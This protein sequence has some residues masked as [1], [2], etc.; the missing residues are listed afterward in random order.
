M[1]D[2]QPWYQRLAA[3]PNT[4]P[5]QPSWRDDAACRGMDVDLFFPDVGVTYDSLLENV[6][7]G[8][9]QVRRECGEFGDTQ[10]WGIWGGKIIGYTKSRYKAPPEWVDCQG[11]GKSIPNQRGGRLRK[12]CG[13]NCRQQAER[14]AS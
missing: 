12:W 4:N 13:A 9:C 7:C 1:R 3:T 2:T 10:P 14:M 11:C 5:R 6:P 8:T